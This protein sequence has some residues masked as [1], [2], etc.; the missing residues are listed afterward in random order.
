MATGNDAA[1][2]VSAGT[3]EKGNRQARC[4]KARLSALVVSGIFLARNLPSLCRQSKPSSPI[5]ASQF[6]IAKAIMAS[7]IG[8]VPTGPAF[9]NTTALMAQLDVNGNEWTND[10]IIALS[11][12]LVTVTMVPLGWMIKRALMRRCKYFLHHCSSEGH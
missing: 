9:N 10:S 12:L 5:T 11:T 3:S 6:G 7:N 8:T 4:I 1:F 2:K